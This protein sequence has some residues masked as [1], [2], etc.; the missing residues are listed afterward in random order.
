MRVLR[1]LLH[2]Q[3]ADGRR[4]PEGTLTLVVSK[5]SRHQEKKE[6]SGPISGVSTW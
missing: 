2:W 4:S 3:E 1:E 6:S 5:S